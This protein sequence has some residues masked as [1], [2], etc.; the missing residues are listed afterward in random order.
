M[1]VLFCIFSLALSYLNFSIW[2]ILDLQNDCKGSKRV[3]VY[4]HLVFPIII[5]LHY[6]GTFLQLMNQYWYIIINLKSIL[7]SDL[8]VLL[9]ILLLFQGPVLE[10]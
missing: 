6:Y 7:Y 10:P 9:N 3:P 1:E 4:P 2:L 8:F 5:I